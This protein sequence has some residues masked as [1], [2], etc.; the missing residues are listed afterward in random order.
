M[1]SLSYNFPTIYITNISH[2]NTVKNGPPAQIVEDLNN[3]A[4]L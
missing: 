2:F 3:K 4:K 1:N